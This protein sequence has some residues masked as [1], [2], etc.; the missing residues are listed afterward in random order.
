M[1]ED[2]ENTQEPL[3]QCLTAQ[4]AG[5]RVSAVEAGVW[6]LRTVSQPDLTS[7]ESSDSVKSP[8]TN[9]QTD[10]L[11]EYLS[12][13]SRETENHKNWLQKVSVLK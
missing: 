12:F 7:V 6:G 2:G 4:H 5:A 10:V 1:V 13:Q 8:R 9:L 11:G 3:G